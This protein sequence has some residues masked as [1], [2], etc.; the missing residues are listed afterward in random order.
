MNVGRVNQSKQE[1]HDIQ[2]QRALEAS[3]AE[4]QAGPALAVDLETNSMHVYRSRLCFVQLA[5]ESEIFIVDALAQGVDVGALRAP[6]LDR[7]LRKVFHDAQGDLR[8]LASEGLH[9]QGLFDTQ[10]AAMLLGLPRIGLG[11]L[12]E[13][14]FGVKLAKE[15]QTANFGERPL[16]TELRSYV[17]DDVRY[18]LLLAEQLEEEARQQ[19]I[20]E[21]LE[22]EFQRIATENAE[23]ETPPRPRL[24]GQ[25]RDALGLA[26]AEAADRLRHREAEKRDLPVGRVL[27]NAAVGEVALRRPRSIREL[28]RLP[29]VKGSFVRPAG[30]ELVEEIAK[31]MA[32]DRKGELPAPPRPEG[33]RDPLRKGREDRL[34]AWRA[35]AALTR[36]VLPAVVLPTYLVERLASEPP[37]DLEE[38]A[39]VPWFGEKRVKLYGEQ[40]VGLLKQ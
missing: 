26:I 32:K 29:G 36:K 17:A 6:F 4:L 28:A 33:R 11:D 35:E 22:L 38:L 25:A 2:G 24:P 19:G 39:S 23:P 16:P 13:E 3:I 15:H 21:E 27:A 8:V 7:S 14:R 1:E 18:L 37:R 34:K 31:L 5:T 12:V 10:R 9:V 20:L 30:D 40:L